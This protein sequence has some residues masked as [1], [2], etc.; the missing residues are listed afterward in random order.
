MIFIYLWPKSIS[1]SYVYFISICA[2]FNNSLFI[3]SDTL[4]SSILYSLFTLF[5]YTFFIILSHLNIIFF[6]HSLLLFTSNNYPYNPNSHNPNPSHPPPPPQTQHNPITGHHKPTKTPPQLFNH[7]KSR[8]N[9]DQIH[10]QIH[11]RDQ[12]HHRE[13]IKS[14]TKSEK[15]KSTT[16]TK[17][18]AKST[19][20]TEIVEHNQPRPRSAI[21][22]RDWQA[23]ARFQPPRRQPPC[24]QLANPSS[25]RAST[26]NPKRRESTQRREWRAESTERKREGR[27]RKNRSK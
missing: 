20:V 22:G 8:P 19:T 4:S 23:Q 26:E 17:F 2:L 16:V 18:T 25:Y 13:K 9:H 7:R 12:I 14:T 27:E 24:L 1:S 11:S 5:K 6:I 21:P 15:I 3:F 10:R